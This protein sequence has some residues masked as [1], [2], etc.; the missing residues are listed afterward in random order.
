MSIFQNDPF[1]ATSTFRGCACGQHAS[2]AEHDALPVMSTDALLDRTLQCGIL[3]AL[4]PNDIERR[5]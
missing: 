4:F 2:Q 1:S 3:A 5:H